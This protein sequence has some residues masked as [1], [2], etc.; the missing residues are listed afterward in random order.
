MTSS[1]GTSRAPSLQDG[2]GRTQHLGRPSDT[3]VVLGQLVNKRVVRIVADAYDRGYR[4]RAEG[5]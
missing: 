5:H 4:D 1:T 2:S 3:A